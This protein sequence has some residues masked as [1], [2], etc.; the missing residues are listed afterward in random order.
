MRGL[1][2]ALLLLVFSLL[3]S[4][5]WAE[6]EPSNQ[7][8]GFY[9]NGSLQNA[10]H[11]AVEG[12]GYTSFDLNESSTDRKWGSQ[13]LVRIIET[14]ADFI[15]D[16]Y[17]D[18]PYL[19][20]GDLSAE[21]GGKIEPH[22]SHQNGLDADLYFLRNDGESPEKSLVENGKLLSGFDL[23]KNYILIKMLETT[24]RINRIF[25]DAAVKKA[26]CELYPQQTN[27]LRRLRPFPGHEA[28]FHVRL[29]CPVESPSCVSQQDPEEG[30][31]C[32]EV[33]EIPPLYFNFQEMLGF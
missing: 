12:R 32:N 31:G 26:Y 24:N 16:F 23:E 9:S 8:L 25:A 14:V 29:T 27:L 28:H 18:G 6:P 17:P 33:T 7:V 21:T 15:Y 4:T 20:I 11:L 13:G 10:T 19:V 5:S 3:S 22:V 30:S 2:L 1:S